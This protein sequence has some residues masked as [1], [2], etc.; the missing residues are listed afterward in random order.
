MIS[1]VKVFVCSV[2]GKRVP[3]ETIPRGWVDLD[4]VGFDFDYPNETCS[5]DHL[6]EE[7]RL[8]SVDRIL[9]IAKER[10]DIAEAQTH[11]DRDIFISAR[12]Y[13]KT[14][15]LN[16]FRDAISASTVTWNWDKAL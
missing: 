15:A 6:C 9:R 5:A 8:G 7:C 12:G 1:N 11:T 10:K 4:E 2:C 14:N 13:G 16:D 3:S